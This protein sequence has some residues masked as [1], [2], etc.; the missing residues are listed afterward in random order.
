MSL[1]QKLV[2]LL[3]LL[4]HFSV[5]SQIKSYHFNRLSQKE[6]LTSQNLNYFVSIDKE[7]FIWIS[8]PLGFNR[9]DGVTVKQYLPNLKDSFAL[10]DGNILSNIYLDKVGNEWFSSTQNIYKYEKKIDGFQSFKIKENLNTPYYLLFSDT[11]NETLLFRLKNQL[12]QVPINDFSSYKKIGNFNLN[13]QS[14]ILRHPINKNLLLI[15][16]NR[17]KLEIVEINESGLVIEQRE[18]LDNITST[19]L[20]LLDENNAFVGTEEGLIHLNLKNDSFN[21]YNNLDNQIIEKIVDIEVYDASTLI[22]ATKSDGL[23]FF[24]T[25][26][27]EFSSIY[28]YKDSILRPFKHPIDKITILKNKFLIVSTSGRGI[29]FT[30]LKGNKFSHLFQETDPNQDGN[31]L[32]SIAQD[33]M[34]RSWILG[35]K[36]LWV[37][38]NAGKELDSMNNY[39][40][41]NIPFYKDFPYCIN[42]DNKNNFWIGCQSGLYFLK[43][44]S[45]T[46]QTL[47]FKSNSIIRPFPPVTRITQLS[48]NQILLSTLNGLYETS[49]PSISNSLIDLSH[50]EEGSFSWVVED[51]IHK[52][53]ILN[54][55]DK[56][57]LI[58]DLSLR[59]KITFLE[60]TPFI[61]QIIQDRNKHF[62]W[63]ASSEGLYKLI[64]KGEKYIIEK[65]TFFPLLSTSH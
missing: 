65:D 29:Y 5:F 38:N 7:G 62:F 45:S 23:Y 4:S 43:N 9:F 16:P 44:E 12:F 36:G 27:K 58:K 50:L 37:F 31:S 33:Q 39:R 17:K 1:F 21:I 64:F 46:F 53:I 24:D 19:S 13:T 48:S 40:T 6:N 32:R 60:F 15:L 61:N 30:N 41:D 34:D 26:K 28:D 8:S 20:V 2:I 42:I 35:N 59:Q 18:Y 49:N 55:V 56:G 3:F 10:K 22:V 47:K 14:T 54:E 11:L 63:L 25:K 52:R 57:F 51:T